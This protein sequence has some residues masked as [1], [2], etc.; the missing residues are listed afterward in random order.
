MTM[1]T[2]S[3]LGYT[4]ID[5]VNR[6]CKILDIQTRT[7]CFRQLRFGKCDANFATLLLD[8]RRD[9]GVRE[10]DNQIAF[11]LLATLKINIPN[12][13]GCG[14][15]I[16]FNG[17]S[18]NGLRHRRSGT[19]QQRL[20]RTNH[21]VKVITLNTGRVRRKRSKVNNQTG[22]IFSLD[23]SQAACITRTQLTILDPQLAGD[24]R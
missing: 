5:K 6:R 2:L 13:L 10:I 22:A 8:I 4:G 18:L 11:T 19:R 7:Q 24:S 23:Y 21:H 15:H 17:R 16:S 14:G 12:C 20:A 1:D 3:P 9:T